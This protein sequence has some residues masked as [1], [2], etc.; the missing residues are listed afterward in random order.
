MEKSSKIYIAGHTGMLGSN[1]LSLLNKEGYNN[2]I[3]RTHS[4]LDLRN[5]NEVENFFK[6][7]RPEY[8]FFCAVNFGGIKYHL[9]NSANIIYDNSLMTLNVVHF[10]KVYNVKKIVLIGSSCIYPDNCRQPMFEE[11]LLTGKL[12]SATEGYSISKILGIKLSELYFKQYGLKSITLVPCN[13]YGPGDSFDPKTSRVLCANIKKYVDAKDNNE[14]QIIMWGTGNARREFLHV[15]DLARACIYFMNKDIEESYINIG[16]GSDHSIKEMAKIIQTETGYNG[17][18]IWD[19]SQPEGSQVK[20]LEVS[21]MLKYGF[22]PE[23][24]LKEGIK[25]MIEYYKIIKEKETLC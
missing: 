4:Q 17:E 16:H 23:I 3:Y 14:Q 18:I 2:I 5:Q 15:R 12:E 13:L 20:C 8:V 19:I 11:D 6:K 1:L 10:S 7:E 22:K 9:S 24:S 25:E 21:K